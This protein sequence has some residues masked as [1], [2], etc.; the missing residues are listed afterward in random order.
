LD[1]WLAG[2]GSAETLPELSDIEA[3]PKHKATVERLY[4]EILSMRPS[5]AFAAGFY[6]TERTNRPYGKQCVLGNGH[7]GAHCTQRPEERPCGV[8]QRIRNHGVVH[9]VRW[10]EWN[11]RAKCRELATVCGQF[12]TTRNRTNNTKMVTCLRCL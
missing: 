4:T 10:S 2:I 1:S 11:E 5:P 7:A 8:T 9:R 3:S 6:C 12:F